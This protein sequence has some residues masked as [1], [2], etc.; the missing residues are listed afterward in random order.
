V[1]LIDTS[2]VI[3]YARGK[4]AKLA[5]LIPQLSVAVCGIVR[6][7]FLCGARDPTHRAQMLTLLATF[8]Q[9]SIPDAV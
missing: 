1:I 9:L 5:A 7:E 8:A 3:D 4:D 6:A 2:V